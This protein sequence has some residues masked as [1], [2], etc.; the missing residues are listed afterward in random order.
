MR[1][2]ANIQ[3]TA[4]RAVPTLLLAALALALSGCATGVQLFTKGQVTVRG[5]DGKVTASYAKP[6]RIASFNSNV[7]AKKLSYTGPDGIKLEIEGPEDGLMFDNASVVKAWCDGA[8]GIVRESTTGAFKVGAGAALPT[9]FPAL[10]T[11]AR[12]FA[13]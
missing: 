5:E 11:A 8:Q 12:A 1:A 6:V 4:R 9:I 7:K 2:W 3:R 10:S 13:P